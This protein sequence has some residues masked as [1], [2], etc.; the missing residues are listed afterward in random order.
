MLVVNSVRY[1]EFCH[2][3]LA[4]VVNG[5]DIRRENRVVMLM[6]NHC[7]IRPPEECLRERR[8][9]EKAHLNSEICFVG[10]EGETLSAF[11]SAHPLHFAT[12]DSLAAIGIVLYMDISGQIC[13]R[14]MVLRPIKFYTSANP[15]S[16]QT[17]Q[18]RLYYFIEIYKMTFADFV[19][20]HLHSA[21]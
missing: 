16:S 2:I 10:I 13:G 5:I 3:A 4:V 6:N 14:T 7:R 1:R 19:P 17:Y 15:R 8:S 20:C 11:G 21:S 18:C 9:V 12:P